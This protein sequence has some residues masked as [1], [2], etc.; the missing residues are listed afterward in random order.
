[1]KAILIDAD[2]KEIADIV[3]ALRSQQQE[4]LE[5]C[6]MNHKLNQYMEDRKRA[7][8]EIQSREIYPYFRNGSTDDAERTG[9][10]AWVGGMEK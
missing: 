4:R 10:S 1:M 9:K 5:D 8:E 6:S 3:L 7:W 2:T